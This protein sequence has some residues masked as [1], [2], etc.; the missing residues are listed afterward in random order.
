MI[1]GALSF[2]RLSWCVAEGE[3]A[4]RLSAAQFSGKSYFVKEKKNRHF[5]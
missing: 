5:I 4:S 3:M 1:V 2:A